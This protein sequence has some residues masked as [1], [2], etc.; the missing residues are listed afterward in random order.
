MSPTPSQSQKKKSPKKPSQK[1]MTP[2]YV[3]DD[4]EDEYRPAKPRKTPLATPRIVAPPPPPPRNRIL[5]EYIF[6][7]PPP[8]PPLPQWY[9]NMTTP[10]ATAK[11]VWDRER[12]ARKPAT[13]EPAEMKRWKEMHGPYSTYGPDG[14]IL[15]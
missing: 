12:W 10:Q 4:T 5:H 1:K 8:P 3:G 13:M 9:L 7:K 2:I 11:Q 14:S 15:Y 6:P